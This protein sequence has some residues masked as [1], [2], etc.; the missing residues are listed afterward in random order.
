MR[1]VKMMEMKEKKKVELPWK[2][3]IIVIIL[4]P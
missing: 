3:S 1:T 4:L 2:P